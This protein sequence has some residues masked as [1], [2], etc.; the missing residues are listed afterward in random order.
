MCHELRK[1]SS[2]EIAPCGRGSVEQLI[3][4]SADSE[5]RPQEAISLRQRGVCAGMEKT[6]S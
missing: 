2:G 6:P 1:K 5:P 4:H 3:S